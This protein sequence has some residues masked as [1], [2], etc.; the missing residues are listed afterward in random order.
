M[1]SNK[2]IIGIF[3]VSLLSL[4]AFANEPDE[5]C[6][7]WFRRAKIAL[8]SKGCELKCASLITDMGTFMCPD[9]CDKLCKP[10]EKESFSSK[11]VFYPG[12][13]QAEKELVVK[14]P[15]QAFLA[16]KQKGLAENST[17]RNFPDQN[18]NDE[19]DAF[20][21]FIWAGLL[22]K[23]LG[24]QRAKEYLDAHETDPDQP[25]I[26]RQMDSFNNGKGQSTAESLIQNKNWSLRNLESEGLKSLHAKELKVISPGLA[27]P[28]EP[29]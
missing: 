24:R 28:K 19:S 3:V 20:R 21:H 10:K 6:M 14:N 11:F 25:E 17:D 22:T 18:L 9:Q 4:S 15:K 5:D 8:G 13:T 29:K 23:E 7:E 2:N 12:L 16:F 26:E 27:I 1:I